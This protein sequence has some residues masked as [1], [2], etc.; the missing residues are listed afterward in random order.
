MIDS[1]QMFSNSTYKLSLILSFQVFNWTHTV[2]RW[3]CDMIV[4]LETLDPACTSGLAYRTLLYHTLFC[5]TFEAVSTGA[6]SVWRNEQP[7]CNW[8]MFKNLCWTL[9]E[10]HY[11]CLQFNYKNLQIQGQ[12]LEMQLVHSYTCIMLVLYNNFT[13]LLIY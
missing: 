8:L 1:A 9:N 4:V 5:F 13:Y 6:I 11:L 12:H 10:W 7:R 3:C 2:T